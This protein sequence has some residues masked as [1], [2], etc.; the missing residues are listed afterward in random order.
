VSFF[1]FFFF[2]TFKVQL[3]PFWFQLGQRDTWQC[4]VG[5]GVDILV[6]SL[7]ARHSPD[8][9]LHFV[10]SYF[11]S[12]MPVKRLRSGPTG[13]SNVMWEFTLFFLICK[14]FRGVS[15]SSPMPLKRLR[16]RPT[17]ASNVMWD[18]LVVLPLLYTSI[19]MCIDMSLPAQRLF[20][21]ICKAFRG[22]LFSSPMPL[23]RLRSR[24]TGASNVMW[25]WFVVLPLLCISM[26][27]EIYMYRKFYWYI[28]IYIQ[29]IY[30][31][32]SFPKRYSSRYALS[33]RGVLFS[34]PMPVKRL[35]LGWWSW[36][37]WMMI[38]SGV[39]SF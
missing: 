15:F 14:A 3:V 11:S 18:W 5:W 25:D 31:D 13:T 36:C 16:S 6:I 4:L 12:P 23:K 27:I 7:F 35:R 30:T 33:F 29:E 2:L 8:M 37:W 19:A 9:H 10:E 24:P 34:L 26:D 38:D 1:S 17:G 20:F 22:V 32:M 39:D 28:Y 21:L